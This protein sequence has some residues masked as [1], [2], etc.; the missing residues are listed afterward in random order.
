[1]KV[2]SLDILHMPFSHHIAQKYMQFALA[3]TCMHEH[4]EPHCEKITFDFAIV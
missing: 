2:Y 3:D 1:M 4:G